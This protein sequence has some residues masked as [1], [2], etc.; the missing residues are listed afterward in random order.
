MYEVERY[1]GR[2]IRKNDSAC[3]IV[4]FD[5]LQNMEAWMRMMRT[6]YNPNMLAWCINREALTIAM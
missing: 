6:W 4:Q 5:T 2:Q 1:G 3:Y